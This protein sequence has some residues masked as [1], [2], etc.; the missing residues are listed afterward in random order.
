MEKPPH[1]QYTNSSPINGITVIKLVMT[2]AAQK[3]IWPQGN[4]YPR[5]A[6]PINTRYIVT[7][8]NH[9]FVRGY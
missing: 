2:V 8:V 5:K 3:L 1:T 4:T 7:P 6:V 9:T